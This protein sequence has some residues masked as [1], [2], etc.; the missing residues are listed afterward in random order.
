M[1]VMLTSC[2]TCNSQKIFQKSDFGSQMGLQNGRSE[3]RKRA[4]DSNP[5]SK[6]HLDA[7]LVD[8]G[9]ILNRFWD[10]FGA[11][12]APKIDLRSVYAT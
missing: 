1:K 12:L 5:V 6:S 9:T 8:F 3:L 7:I 11:I 10:G 2:G 4:F